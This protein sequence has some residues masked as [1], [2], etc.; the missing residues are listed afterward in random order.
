[1]FVKTKT[2]ETRYRPS[3]MKFN[4]F[5][6]NSQWKSPHIILACVVNSLLVTGSL[7]QSYE[8]AQASY[9]TQIARVIT[10]TNPRQLT[11]GIACADPNERWFG[12]PNQAAKIPS[13]FKGLGRLRGEINGP[14]CDGSLFCQQT[15][16]SFTGT[17]VTGCHV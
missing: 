9:C 6:Q 16:V 2:N 17:L 12:F 3:F 7:V 13:A 14:L 15:Y 11:E 5:Y 10:H 4:R 8:T 1:M